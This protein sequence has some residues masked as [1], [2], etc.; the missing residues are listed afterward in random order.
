MTCLRNSLTHSAT[1]GERSPLI[2]LQSD[3]S[4]VTSLHNVVERKF[5]F[6]GQFIKKCVFVLGLSEM[7]SRGSLGPSRPVSLTSSFWVS[8]IRSLLILSGTHTHCWVRKALMHAQ[9]VGQATYTGKW[10]EV[11]VAAFSGL[12]RMC[13]Y[14]QSIC[15]D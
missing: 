15:A 8:F 1:H 13:Q 5:V 4:N 3:L 6:N 14:H 7:T 11:T 10:V 12:L 9:C 2:E